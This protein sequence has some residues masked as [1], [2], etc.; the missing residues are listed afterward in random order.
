MKDV[1]TSCECID[2]VWQAWGTLNTLGCCPTKSQST[3]DPNQGGE[4]VVTWRTISHRFVVTCS[5]WLVDVCTRSDRPGTQ[6]QLVHWGAIHPLNRA[7]KLWD[8]IWKDLQNYHTILVVVCTVTWNH[9]TW[10]CCHPFHVIWCMVK[11]LKA[12]E[13][14]NTIGFYSSK[15][16]STQAVGPD[17]VRTTRP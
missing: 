8:L 4:Y 2:K 16:Q 1:T 12:W 10:I 6:S 11:V 15:P 17:L 7:P 3:Q 9:R 14:I 5:I 13:I